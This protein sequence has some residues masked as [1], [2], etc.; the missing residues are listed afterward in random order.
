VEADAEQ[1]QRI[2]ERSLGGDYYRPITAAFRPDTRPS[3]ELP[4]L[5]SLAHTDETWRD[6]GAGGGRLAIPLAKLVRR[7]IAVEPSES[8]RETLRCAMAGENADVEIDDRSWPVADEAAVEPVDVALSAHAIY[9]TADLGAYLDAMER[10]TRRLCV[11]VLADHAR[12][13][14]WRD[15]F[16]AVHGERQAM[17]PALTEFVAVLGARGR[18]FDVRTVEAEPG[19]PVSLDAALATGRRFLWLTDGSEKDGLL[20]RVVRERFTRPDG[21][22]NAPAARRYLAV[23]TW[24]PNAAV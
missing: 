6:I 22:V 8:Q 16:E 1:V 2:S 12:G 11:V 15:V 9:D 17:L 5:E 10:T 20:Q 24:E 3:P 21:L 23:V 13:W 18:R 4:I 19:G 7:V 14:Y